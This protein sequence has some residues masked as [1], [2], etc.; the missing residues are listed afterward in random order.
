MNR[1]TRRDD[2]SK[3][4]KSELENKM[5]RESAWKNASKSGALCWAWLLVY[6]H[7]ETQARLTFSGL[8]GDCTVEL[9]Q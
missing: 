4:M 2:V 9:L 5:E 7:A 3:T 1:K 6:A 8:Y